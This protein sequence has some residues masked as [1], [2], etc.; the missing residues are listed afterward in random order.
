MSDTNTKSKNIGNI[1]I[2]F[3]KTS[4]ISDE[5]VTKVLSWFIKNQAYLS[6]KIGDKSMVAF[7]SKYRKQH[8][9][10]AFY[11]PEPTE[12]KVEKKATKDKS[13]FPF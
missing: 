13:D 7:A 9:D 4:N 6:V 5:E 11:L 2:N 3:P 10:P 12:K 8:K 1:W